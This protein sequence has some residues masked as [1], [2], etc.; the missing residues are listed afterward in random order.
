MAQENPYAARPWH[1]YYHDVPHEI[2]PDQYGNMIDYLR[3]C[4][5]LFKDQV[6]FENMGKTMTYQEVDHLSRDFAAWLQQRGLQNGD[7]IAIQMPN[8]LQFPI[9]L[10]GAIRAGLIVVNTNPLY[11]TQEM[12]HQFKDLSL[13]H[14]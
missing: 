7:R 1:Q 4:F 10:F 9:A 13:I 14:I 8:L 5:D 2:D 12:A 6:A 3:R 11:T